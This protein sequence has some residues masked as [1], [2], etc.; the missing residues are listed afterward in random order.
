M[1]RL[2]AVMLFILLGVV[3]LQNFFHYIKN[4]PQPLSEEAVK[5]L[6]QKRKMLALVIGIF[7]VAILLFF[8]L[9][10]VIAM[11]FFLFTLF[12]TLAPKGDRNL[13]LL[14]P[15][16]I[17]APVVIHLVFLHV[18]YVLLPPAS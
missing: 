13:K 15:L 16:A 5:K 2:S 12:Y 14:I 7:L 18:F 3:L 11:A 8:T 1:P 4:P 17:F 6:R 10:F 9:G